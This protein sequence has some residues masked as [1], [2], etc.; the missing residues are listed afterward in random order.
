VHSLS[1]NE[2]IDVV[3]SQ[4]A[5]GIVRTALGNPGKDII[6]TRCIPVRIDVDHGP[7]DLKECDHLI[8]MWID[9][10]RMGFARCLLNIASFARDPI[11][12]EISPFTL[13]YQ[14]MHG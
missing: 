14:T 12:L 8:D 10:Q 9:H 6:E 11:V 1:T 5:S 2:R 3:W 4:T 7:V 13:E